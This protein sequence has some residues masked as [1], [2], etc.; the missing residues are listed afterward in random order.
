MSQNQIGIFNNIQWLLKKVKILL[1]ITYVAKHGSFEDLTTQTS[2]GT[3]AINIVNFNQ[4]SQAT[5]ISVVSNSQIT[6]E[7]DGVYFVN[8]LGQFFF[9]G[10]A[11]NYNITVWYRINGVDIPYSAYTFTT[12]GAQNN[13]T[14]GNLEDIIKVKAGDYLEI[15]WWA[16]AAGVALTP[17]N[18]GTNPTRPFSPSVN[19]NTWKIA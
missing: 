2:A 3:T 9:T 10:G 1:G 16:A 4:T 15:C 17:T 13:Q 18:N 5:G 8:F 12:T 19:L 14:L 11:S 7:S 6:F